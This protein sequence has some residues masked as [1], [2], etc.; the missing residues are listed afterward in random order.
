MPA[1]DRQRVVD[2][3][4]SWVG[5][6]YVPGGAVKGAGADCGMLLIR[7]FQEM[8][9]LDP[10]FDPRPYPQQWHMHQAAERYLG[11]VERFA[12]ALPPDASPLPGDVVLFKFGKCFSHGAI[13]V[14]WPEIVH[15]MRPLK[16]GRVNVLRAGVMSQLERRFF[17]VWSD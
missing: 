4:L 3:A 9:Y 17:S 8:G 16:V 12:H 7:V 14:D 1:S 2:E 11:Y 6:P 5:T 10:A 13:I 15:A